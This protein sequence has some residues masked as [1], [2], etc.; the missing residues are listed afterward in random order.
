M[1]L[2]AGV[3]TRIT[4]HALRRGGI[5]E[6]HSEDGTRRFFLSAPCTISSRLLCSKKSY[7]DTIRTTMDGPGQQP[8]VSPSL[9][10]LADLKMAITAGVEMACLAL[11]AGHFRAVERR[12]LTRDCVGPLQATAYNMRAESDFKGGIGLSS[13][14]LSIHREETQAPGLMRTWTLMIWTR[15]T[16]KAE[17]LL[18]ALWRRTKSVS[19]NASQ[20]E[21][22]GSATSETHKRP[23]QRGGR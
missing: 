12:G 11:V 20:E 6:M 19:I 5:W 7:A 15:R 17:I 9:Y 16:V 13:A 4:S 23:A 10:V 21:T 2:A 18:K 1:G 14:L 22:A 3:L 8:A